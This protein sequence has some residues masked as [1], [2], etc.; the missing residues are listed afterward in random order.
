MQNNRPDCLSGKVSLVLKQ[1]G[2]QTVETTVLQSD[3]CSTIGQ[4]FYN[5]TTVLHWETKTASGLDKPEAVGLPI[6]VTSP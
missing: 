1:S 6:A 3:N 4:L 2:S 5:R